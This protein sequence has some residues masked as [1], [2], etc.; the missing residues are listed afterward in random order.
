MT[1][2]NTPKWDPL[3]EPGYVYI[4]ADEYYLY[5]DKQVYEGAAVGVGGTLAIP[6]Q[7]WQTKYPVP[8][9]V[10]VTDS[11][12]SGVGELST[13]VA[14]GTPFAKTYEPPVGVSKEDRTP[15]R[16][17]RRYDLTGFK[18]RE[19]TPTGY[20]PYVFELEDHEYSMTYEGPDDDGFYTPLLTINP[21]GAHVV[22]EY[23]NPFASSLYRVP[24][25]DLN[26]THSV[27]VGDKFVIVTD[28]TPD[29]GIVVVTR[30]DTSNLADSNELVY[31]DV[32]VNTT[33]GTPVQNYPV[34][35]S[36]APEDQG[37]LDSSGAVT[38]W[39]GTTSGA[40]VTPADL[41]SFP[42]EGVVITVAADSTTGTLGIEAG[43]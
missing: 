13:A 42:A 18:S 8:A 14:S 41:S 39:D 23:E 19:L 17:R 26:P 25:I 11:Y 28:T 24:D 43:M 36:H 7:K 10:V 5:V 16:Y 3:V 38:A 30:R 29:P 4:S 21:S 37:Y 9:P 34:S 20:I 12:P 1:E 15:F 32:V 22:V 31:F 40:Y 35:M 2:F 33:T 27:N 6:A